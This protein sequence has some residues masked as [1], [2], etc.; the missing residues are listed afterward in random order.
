MATSV[1]EIAELVGGVVVGETAVRITGLNGIQ[2]AQ[3]GDLTFV[4]NRQYLPFLETTQAHAVLIAPDLAAEGTVQSRKLSL[5]QVKNPYAAF[6]KVL[7]KHAA[8]APIPHPRGIHPSAVVGQN[9]TLGENVALDAHVRIA[10]DCVLGD[11]VVLYAG[12]Y[13][14][15]GCRV[16]EQTVIYPKVVLREGV[17]VGARCIIHAGVVLGSDGFGFALVDGKWFKVPQVGDVFIEDDVEI[18][19]NSAIDR[20]TFGHTVV[21]RGTKIDNLV[22]IGHNVVIGQDCV[23]SGMTGIAGSCTI[24]NYVIIA[25]QVGIADHV[26]IGDGVTIGGRSGVVGSIKPGKT[27]SGYPAMD[28]HLEKRVL[29]GAKYLPEMPRR[30]RDLERRLQTLEEQLHG[31]AED[32]R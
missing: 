14:G 8:T 6:I 23:I 29:A 7:Q 2:Q 1:G 4:A 20:A 19:A 21:G 11:N 25:A 3:S 27:V 13:I 18:G 17:T 16:G 26:D 10:D 9:V 30:L 22:Q 32:D 15:R 12:V 5:I 28:H 24:G 31:Q